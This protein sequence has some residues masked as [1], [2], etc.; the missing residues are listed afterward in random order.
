[1]NPYPFQTD[2]QNKHTYKV[3]FLESVVV[4]V[5]YSDIHETADVFSKF[6]EQEFGIEMDQ[7]RFT[8]KNNDCYTIKDSASSKKIKFSKRLIEIRMD[9]ADYVN[10]RQSILPEFEKVKDYL[11]GINSEAGYMA[12]EMIDIWP[13]QVGGKIDEETF[14]RVVFSKELLSGSI[15]LKEDLSFADFI[16]QEQNDILTIRHGFIPYDDKFIDQPARLVLDTICRHEGALKPSELIST[17]VRLNDVLYAAYH[18]SVTDDVIKVMKPTDT[19][20]S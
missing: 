10:F 2:K 6:M 12:I 13:T 1:M 9:G 7:A 17:A 3:T 11:A 5:E 15:T 20:K 18:W 14:R 16:N 8:L 4:R 19:Q